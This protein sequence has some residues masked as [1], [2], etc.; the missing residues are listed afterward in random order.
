MNRKH[1]TACYQNWKWNNRWTNKRE[2]KDESWRLEEMYFFFRIK[3]RYSASERK[4]LLLFWK[5]K[6]ITK[7]GLVASN[8]GV[9]LP[10]LKRWNDPRTPKLVNWKNRSKERWKRDHLKGFSMSE[11]ELCKKHVFKM[12]NTFYWKRDKNP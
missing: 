3:V 5:K 1:R 4:T 9:F 11:I 12:I 6:L 8:G 7:H 2:I 10:I